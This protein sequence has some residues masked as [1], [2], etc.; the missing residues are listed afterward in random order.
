MTDQPH[1]KTTYYS[2]TRQLARERARTHRR[3]MRRARIVVFAGAL[4]CAAFAASSMATGTSHK[5][6]PAAER[7]GVIAAPPDKAKKVV[8]PT[9]AA[10]A[11]AAAKPAVHAATRKVTARGV[12]ASPAAAPE[13]TTKTTAATTTTRETTAPV[14][15]AAASTVST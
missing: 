13:I 14:A 2:P 15:V 9:V 12:P 3:N 6:T 8:A 11:A 1:M 7:I 5:S 4:I 10:P